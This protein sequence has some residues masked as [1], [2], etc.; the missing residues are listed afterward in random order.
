MLRTISGQTAAQTYVV[1]HVW[2]WCAL[3]WGAGVFLKHSAW[4][5][6]WNATET[7]STE[8]RSRREL[9]TLQCRWKTHLPAAS[10]SQRSFLVTARYWGE[11]QCQGSLKELRME[12]FLGSLLRIT[13]HYSLDP[14][15][16]PTSFIW[17]V[18]INQTLDSTAAYFP[19]QC[20][21]ASDATITCS[22]SVQT[23]RSLKSLL[24]AEL[25]SAQVTWTWMP[26]PVQW[27]NLTRQKL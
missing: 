5:G 2:G 8:G 21:L 18:H 24:S 25:P 4:Q 1:I 7:S 22:A 14:Q 26:Y 9:L 16:I 13:P 15:L 6:I 3:K 12:N 27:Q 19:C 20:S 10:I 17:K 11:H 23:S